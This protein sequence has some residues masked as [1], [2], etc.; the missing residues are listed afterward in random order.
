M[1]NENVPTSTI[2]VVETEHGRMRR[3]QRGIHKK[4]LQSARKHGVRTPYYRQKNGDRAARYT[5]KNIIY[6]TNEVTKEEITSYTIPLKLDRVPITSEMRRQHNEAVA[7][8][9]K[10]KTKWT[11]NTVIVIDTSGSMK[12]ADVWGARNRL[13]S[14]WISVALDFLATRIENGSGLFDVV[15]IVSMGDTADILIR[16]Q[17]T[18]YVLYN[19]IVNFYTRKTVL[20][21]WHGNYIPA[22]DVAEDL[23]NANTNESCAIGLCFISDGK[24]SDRMHLRVSKEE[25]EQMIVDRIA[26]LAKRFGRTLSFDAVG[27]G[28]VDNF[29][30]LQKMVDEA[31]DYGANASLKL[32]SR[33]SSALGDVLHSFATS[34]TSTQTEMTDMWTSTQQQVRNIERESK[35]EAKTP[36]TCV[37]EEE[38]HIYDNL[39]A[40]RFIWNEKRVD[41]RWKG[42]FEE[43]PLHHAGAEYVALH[44]RP[45]G[46]GKERFAFRFYELHGDR[47][48]IVGKPLV[49]KES[50]FILEKDVD[51]ETARRKYVQ[52]FCKT[53]HLAGCIAKRFNEKLDS[54]YRVDKK[55]ARV[56]MLDCC[57]YEI[58][59]IA[60]GKLSV[61]V[62]ERLDESKWQKWNSNNGFVQGMKAKPTFDF[63]DDESAMEKLQN[64]QLGGGLGGLGLGVLEEGDEEE[65]SESDDNQD[66]PV[67]GA[68]PI[69]FSPFEVAQAFSHFSYWATGK[70]RLICDIQGV[71]DEEKNML[72]L[73]LRLS[74]PVIHYQNYRREHKR[75]VHGK[76]DRGTKGFAMF[77]ETHECSKLC[78][79]VTGGFKNAN[80]RRRESYSTNR[81]NAI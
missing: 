80:R 59:D 24:P 26:S 61:L 71:Y 28:D 19:E 50:R 1:E 23:I 67:E 78:H 12:E 10:D 31:K 14:V 48:T 13:D 49:S 62:E 53:Q 42:V 77:F 5:W 6:I 35:L 79:L 47:K 17:P 52:T 37:S 43:A 57:I 32:P 34:V 11:S 65:D 46:E 63:F 41:G 20:P 25:S 73:M 30:T 22:L 66:L 40:K 21:K 33:T 54:L 29:D 9:R 64:L 18:T 55:T 8:I 51:N 16:E 56:E 76:T 2:T 36:I 45:F 72:R 7:T 15:S 27:I 44:H 74:D 60:L 75:M 3:S 68:K 81:S 70:K 39:Y 69:V 38:F 58:D 4:D